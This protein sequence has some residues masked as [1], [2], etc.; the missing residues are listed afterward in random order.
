MN[1]NDIQ[2]VQKYEDDYD[3]KLEKDEI[4]IENKDKNY[5]DIF[6]IK[7]EKY[8]I[9]ELML[10]FRS[11]NIVKMNKTYD[12]EFK[13][14]YSLPLKDL[15]IF[16][17]KLRN[18]NI[19]KYVFKEPFEMIGDNLARFIIK[20][21]VKGFET[22]YMANCI[23]IDF[24][25]E[26]ALIFK[27]INIKINIFDLLR[28]LNLIKYIKN[29]IEISGETKGYIPPEY[30]YNKDHKITVEEDIKLNYFSLGAT[31][32]YI[33]YGDKMLEYQEFED[34]L[35]TANYMKELIQTIINKIKTTKINDKDFINFLCKLIQYNLN[36]RLSFEEIYRNKWLNKNWNQILEIMETYRKDEGKIIEELNKS[37]FLFG[38]N[39]YINEQRK[40]VDEININIKDN[41]EDYENNNKLK[42]NH[43]INIHKFKLKI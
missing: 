19:L 6:L 29:L 2:I 5:A 36:D 11:P 12:K 17:N 33:K 32:F 31:I 13:G 41:I 39:K 7:E 18:G 26:N 14:K 3:S 16:V 4:K 9:S 25:P 22:L 38:K 8:R 1:K 10:D 35:I 37:D 23:H 43:K 15:K 42:K 40:L 27:N 21:L 28:N 24:K 30:Y 34:K 20:Q